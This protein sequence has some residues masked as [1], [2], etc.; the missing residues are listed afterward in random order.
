MWSSGEAVPAGNL[1]SIDDLSAA[2]EHDPVAAFAE[3]AVAANDHAR[4]DNSAAL[5]HDDPVATVAKV[6]ARPAGDFASVGDP[7]ERCEQDAVAA[8][9]GVK[10]SKA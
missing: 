6:P 5:R 9:A 3:A 7:A 4:I 8:A 1:A 2:R 10:S